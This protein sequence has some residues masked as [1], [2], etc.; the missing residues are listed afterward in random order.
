MGKNPKDYY[1]IKQTSLQMYFPIREANGFLRDL[2]N[3]SPLC[4][5]KSELTL[6]F[7]FYYSRACNLSKLIWL[8]LFLW[9]WHVNDLTHVS[10]NLS[11]CFFTLIQKDLTTHPKRET[12]LPSLY[13]SG[14]LVYEHRVTR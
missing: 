10:A 14:W 7:L 12:F 6:L 4:K 8:R 13:L 5:R 9:S 3:H 2:N 1:F 11:V